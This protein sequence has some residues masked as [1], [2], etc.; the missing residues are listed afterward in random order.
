M[1]A[2]KQE[3]LWDFNKRVLRGLLE[4][5][6]LHYVSEKLRFLRELY[7]FREDPEALLGNDIPKMLKTGDP[8]LSSVQSKCAY[9][10]ECHS[11]TYM[12][13]I[14]DAE[15]S[16][17]P[18]FHYPQHHGAFIEHCSFIDLL[19]EQ[20]PESYRYLKNQTY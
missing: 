9:I 20:G 17:V 8:T 19:F 15:T 12:S 1:E 18:G 6:S 11:H 3:S 5:T 7:N 2:S 14:P 13:P 10:Q 4:F 16:Y